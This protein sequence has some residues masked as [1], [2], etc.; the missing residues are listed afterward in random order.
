MHALKLSAMVAM[1]L[2]AAASVGAQTNGWYTPYV[3]GLKAFDAARYE[4]AVRLLERAVV[5]DPRAARNKYIE[6]VFRTDYLPYY[7]LAI[8][9]SKLGAIDKAQATLAK[10]HGVVPPALVP[11]L[12]DL[13]RSVATGELS[14]PAVVSAGATRAA[15]AANAR[16]RAAIQ[17]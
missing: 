17:A 4:E 3:K 1:I 7:Y 12:R 5:E 16:T 8:A 13:Q 14:P 6:G 9:Y 2:G 15:P 10:A 11:Q